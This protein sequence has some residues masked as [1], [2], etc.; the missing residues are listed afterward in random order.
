MSGNAHEYVTT[1]SPVR[2][3]LQKI[4]FNVSDD[5]V[6]DVVVMVDKDILS[7][8]IVPGVSVGNFNA[9]LFVVDGLP[10]AAYVELYVNGEWVRQ[11]ITSIYMKTIVKRNVVKARIKY[12][13]QM[14]DKVSEPYVKE[15]ND[16][17]AAC[18][19]PP[20]YVTKEPK[21]NTGNYDPHQDE[22]WYRCSC[23]CCGEI[24]TEP[25]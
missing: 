23:D 2:T 3:N 9:K 17:K 20:E 18:K 19:H 15:I 16:L 12:L 5:L 1:F 4:E 25:Q 8:M 6:Y 21:S 22:Y 10:E 11:F 7:K 14:I 24:W 13:Q